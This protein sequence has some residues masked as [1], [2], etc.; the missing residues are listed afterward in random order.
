MTLELTTFAQGYS[1]SHCGKRVKKDEEV[2]QACHGHS[3]GKFSLH[4]HCVL[5]LA[6]TFK[7][8]RPPEDA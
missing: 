7:A 8:P 2:F 4:G 3:R 6:E 1:C 5:E